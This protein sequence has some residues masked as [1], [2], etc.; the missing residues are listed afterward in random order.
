[1]YIL[2]EVKV[3]FLE[4]YNSQGTHFFKAIL[5]HRSILA[6]TLVVIEVE[7]RMEKYE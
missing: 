3:V 1:M 4:Y 6:I 7:E 5:K 2:I